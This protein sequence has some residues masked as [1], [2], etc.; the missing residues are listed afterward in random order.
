MAD[1]PM[2]GP[3][4]FSADQEK[5]MRDMA[6]SV[7]LDASNQ[8]PAISGSALTPQYGFSGAP[9]YG[10]SVNLAPNVSLHGQYQAMPHGHDAGGVMLKYR[11]EF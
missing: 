1:Y 3:F 9:A 2:P 8:G 7:R 10:A 5:A 4:E 6:A 11:S